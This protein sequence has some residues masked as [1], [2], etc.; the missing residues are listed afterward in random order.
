MDEDEDRHP[1]AQGGMTFDQMAA[2][3]Q[4]EWERAEGAEAEARA[5][6]AKIERLQVYG[7]E[8]RQACD[9]YKSAANALRAEV[10][11]AEVRGMRRAAEIAQR[12]DDPVCELCGRYESNHYVRHI[13]VGPVVSPVAAINAA[14]D[15]LEKEKA[16]E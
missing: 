15:K 12:V 11:A 9:L 8:L 2:R 4:Y 16:D 14:A 7:D 10:H 6:H 13:F 5:L 3:A 1:G